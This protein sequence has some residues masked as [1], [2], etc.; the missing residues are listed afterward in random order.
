METIFSKVLDRLPDAHRWVEP[1]ALLL[2]ATC[3]VFGYEEAAELSVIVRDEDGKT[4]FVIGSPGV[5]VVES[6]LRQSPDVREVIATQEYVSNLVGLLPGWSRTSIFVHRLKNPERL[7]VNFRTVTLWEV[8]VDTVE[9]HRRK[10]YA[11][12]CVAHMVMKMRRE[13]QPKEPVWQAAEDDPASCRL[14]EKLGFERADELA[15]FRR[16]E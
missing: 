13:A 3:D 5:P 8:A 4:M 7:V 6:V 9:P 15:W 10:G 16:D 12:L 2:R 1:R 14:A 11:G